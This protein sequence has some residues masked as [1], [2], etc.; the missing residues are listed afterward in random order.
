MCD[1]DVDWESPGANMMG[2]RRTLTMALRTAAIALITA[3]MQEPMAA[4]MF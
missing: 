3:M 4:K 1:L 2:V